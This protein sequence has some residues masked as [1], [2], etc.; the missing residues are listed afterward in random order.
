M[1][2]IF[3]C[4]CLRL[5]E[6]PAQVEALAHNALPAPIPH[7]AHLGAEDLDRG[8]HHR[9]GERLLGAP[10]GLRERRLAGVLARQ[11]THFH[12]QLAPR[13]PRSRW[14]A[15]A[16]GS[17]CATVPAAPLRCRFR[18]GALHR[19]LRAACRSRASCRARP[20][21]PPARAPGTGPTR[22]PP[23][24]ASRG[25]GT[26]SRA[27]PP[28]GA[29]GFPAPKGLQA[30]ED[31]VQREERRQGREPHHA[32]LEDPTS[33]LRCVRAPR[34]LHRPRGGGGRSVAGRR[35]SGAR[36]ARRSA[37]TSASGSSATSARSP[38]AASTARWRKVLEEV[39]AEAL[40]VVAVRVQLGEVAEAGAGVAGQDGVGHRHHQPP[41][42]RAQH[43]AHRGVVGRA[44]RDPSAPAPG[45]TA[46]RAGS[47]PLH[48]HQRQRLVREREAARRRPCGGG[49]R[50]AR[51]ADAP[52]VV[53]L[54]A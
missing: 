51:P 33:G 24:T 27:A 13:L 1:F 26:L 38:V 39:T 54:A 22:P 28:P 37:A 35:P 7:A 10:P 41:V 11:R 25:R 18:C 3:S 5:P 17:P 31:V 14:R 23:G 43:L 42:R 6:E 2:A 45:G 12:P 47:P 48:A 20:A 40:R 53:A 21:S 16:G 9:I 50:A 34:A 32:H 15:S 46:R 19:R 8:L 52:E 36:P 30:V 4:S 44:A 49:A 29:A